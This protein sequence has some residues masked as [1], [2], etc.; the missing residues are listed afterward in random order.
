M[1]QKPRFYT[2]L[3]ILKRAQFCWLPKKYYV[4]KL[5]WK[6][7]YDT[8]RV[9]ILPQL[10]ASWLCFQ[11]DIIRGTDDDWEWWLWV[12]KYNDGD[13]DKA[14]ETWPWGERIDGV[15]VKSTPHLNYK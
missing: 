11:L 10:L 4:K 6:D 12:M 8:P 9:E 14:I 15:F 3:R 2:E 5:L 1:I 7:K 13:I